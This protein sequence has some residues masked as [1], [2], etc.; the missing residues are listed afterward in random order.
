MQSASRDPDSSVRPGT[1]TASQVCALHGGR[2]TLLL[3]QHNNIAWPFLVFIGARAPQLK[4]DKNLNQALLTDHRR[5][6]S[7]GSYGK[8]T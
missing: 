8:V 5:Q 3:K 4:R 6:P 2:G 1:W 7:E